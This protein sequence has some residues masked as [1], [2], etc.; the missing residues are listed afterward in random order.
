M[1]YSQSVISAFL[2]L[3]VGHAVFMGCEQNKSADENTDGENKN[4]VEYA[5]NVQFAPID[6]G[7]FEQKIQV[8]AELKTHRRLDIKSQISGEL[9]EVTV[10]NV[11][12]VDKGD[13]L[14]RFDDDKQRIDYELAKDEYEKVKKKHDIEEYMRNGRSLTGD[15][16]LLESYTG[17]KEAKLKLKKAKIILEESLIRAPFDGIIVFEEIPQEG[18]FINAGSLLAKLIDPESQYLELN[19]LDTHTPLIQTGQRIKIDGFPSIR[20]KITK[21]KPL[22]SGTSNT[23]TAYATIENGVLTKPI[24]SNFWAQIVYNSTKGQFRIPN[25]AVLERNGRPLVF[26]LN[27]NK[28]EWIWLR[29][30]SENETHAIIEGFRLQ[31]ADTIAVDGHYS[32]SHEQRVTPQLIDTGN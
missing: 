26:R 17:L 19:I 24:G 6:T 18:A 16:L 29:S 23:F 3:I 30:Y 22:T 11:E 20:G 10:D 15:T 31:H 7:L 14:F 8:P 5:P 12:R 1:N 27:N 13:I 21:I 28:V 2:L 32:L 9:T 25:T 4:F